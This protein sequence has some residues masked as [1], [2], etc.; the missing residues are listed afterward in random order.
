MVANYLFYYVF[1]HKRKVS[2]LIY[3]FLVILLL[4]PI[5]INNLGKQHKIPKKQSV[6]TGWLQTICFIKFPMCKRKMSNF[7]YLN[8]IYYFLFSLTSKVNIQ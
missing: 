5:F 7:I 1:M 2:N 4:F 8:H 3:Y 6:A